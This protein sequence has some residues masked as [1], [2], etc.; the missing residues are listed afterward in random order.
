MLL[1]KGRGELLIAQEDEEAGLKW[2]SLTLIVD[3]F[4][5]ESKANAVKNRIAGNLEC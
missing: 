4:I 1:G 2:K 5:G 3:V